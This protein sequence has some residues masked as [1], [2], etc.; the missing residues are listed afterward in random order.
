MS[1]LAAHRVA[2]AR[3][4]AG[5]AEPRYCSPSG[6]RSDGSQKGENLPEARVKL[7]AKKSVKADCGPRILAPL[8]LDIGRTA[9]QSQFQT[10]MQIRNA[11]AGDPNVRRVVV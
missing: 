3:N 2:A 5:S 11:K 9:W 4:F 7:T 8:L 10:V 6:G 1:G